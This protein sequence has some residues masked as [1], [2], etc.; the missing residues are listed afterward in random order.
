MNE[1][2][3]KPLQAILSLARLITETQFQDLISA[4]DRQV[5]LEQLNSKSHAEIERI[6]AL[7]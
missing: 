2:D 1:N 6:L 5:Y 3:L 4:D 7:Q